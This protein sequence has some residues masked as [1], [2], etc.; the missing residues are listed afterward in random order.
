[1]PGHCQPGGEAPAL[2]RSSVTRPGKS[3]EALNPW[4]WVDYLEVLS[5][6][7]TEYQYGGHARI[8]DMRAATKKAV[9]V[10]EEEHA[11]RDVHPSDRLDVLIEAGVF[12]RAAFEVPDPANGAEG[13]IRY[14]KPSSGEG[15]PVVVVSWG[16]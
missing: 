9:V 10:L 5:D 12:S 8:R 7:V 14:F 4:T 13:T 15:Q 16:C 11:E 1:V 2:S 6:G 3:R